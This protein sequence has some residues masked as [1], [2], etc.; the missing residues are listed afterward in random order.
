MIKIIKVRAKTRF[1]AKNKVKKL[2][3]KVINV[4]D[5]KQPDLW[6]VYG[7]LK[8]EKK[9]GPYTPKK[10]DG[11][12]YSWVTKRKKK[13]D[14]IKRANVYRREGRARVVYEDGW[15]HVFARGTKHG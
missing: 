9:W 10:F 4:L 3:Y 11:L 14:A 7:E 8:K 2:G 13:K 12:V 1:S 5:T 6:T 15:Y